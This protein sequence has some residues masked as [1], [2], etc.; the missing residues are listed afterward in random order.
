[1]KRILSLL[2]VLVMCVGVFAG[3]NNDKDVQTG[4]TLEQA[5]DYLYNIMKDKN[6]K[7]TP[8]DYDVVGKIIIDSTTFEVTWKTDNENIVVKESSKANCWTIDVP[9]VNETEVKYT[10]TATIKNAAGETIEVS[11][12][13]KLPVIDNA[14]VETEFKEGVA[15]K[16]F[17]KQVNLGYTVY[18]LNTTQNGENKYIETTMDPKEAATFYVEVV[19][20]GYK[21]YTE[22]DGVK[23]YLHAELKAV[24]GGKTSKYIGFSA[25]S[26][27]VF[28]YDKELS[29][30][31]V[32][33][34]G[35][36]YGVG[37]YNNFDTISISEITYFKA[38]NINVEDG[39]F[40]I[41]L[42]TKEYADTLA[43]S[44]KPEHVHEY[45]DGFCSC[46]EA[47]PNAA[48]TNQAPIIT[49][50]TLGLGAYADGSKTLGGV[51]FD[52]I[53]LGTYGDGIQWRNKAAEGGKTSTLWNA[54]ATPMGIEK[55]EITLADGKSG[56]TNTDAL[57]FAFGD[58]A[59]ALTYTTT[60]STEAGVAKYTITPD[61]GTYKFFKIQINITYTVY[62][63]RITIY[64]TGGAAHVHDFVDGECA[65]GESDPDYVP[66]HTC[67]D[68]NGDYVCDAT[69]C[70][71]VVAPAADSVL[72]LEQATAFGVALG[73]AYST[74]KYYVTG[75]ITEVYN[76]TYGNMYIKN[77]NNV[78]FT[79]YGLYTADGATRYD[80]M[81]TKPIAGDVVT[82]YGTIGSYNGTAQMKNGW[83]TD[84]QHEH[85]FEAGECACG[86]ADPDYVP[87]HTCVDA[88]GDY[89]CDATDCDKVVAPAA[90]SVLTLEQA[91]A[92]GVALGGAYSTDKYYV[93]GTITE[94][95]N[96]TYGNAYIK[97]TNNV[98]FTVY[99][100]Y[101]ADGATR[102][103][104]MTTKPVAGDVITVYGTIGSYSGTA[105]MKNGWVT[106]VQHTHAFEA[107][108]CACGAADPDYV[109][110]HEH[111]FVNGECA[112]G[113]TDPN[114]N[115]SE[116][117]DTQEVVL[118]ENLNFASAANK[119]SADTYMKDNYSNWTITGK[120]GQTYGGY[121]GF[122]RSGDV[123]SSIKSSAISVNSEFTITT[124]L[125][126]NGSSGVATSTL[127]FTL[128]DAN[129]NLVATGYADGAT[130]A[131][132]TPVDAKDTTYN[133]SFTLEDGK[134]W[135]DVSNLVISFSKATGN[136]G[137]KS[138]TFVQ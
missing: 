71:K 79:V 123:T 11:F 1:M 15:Y 82:A 34:N 22:I 94:V 4:A 95:Y 14:G 85:A 36:D 70:G 84:L 65:C 2:L 48:V 42:M 3:C 127:T 75:T 57:I 17:M 120:L 23:N 16:I 77:D 69:D 110:P 137:L 115:P 103:D 117:G 88:N 64:Y 97:D 80:A 72:T 121:L 113:E 20:G 35:G 32:T 6:D 7:A 102:Y 58:S 56:Y 91:N 25:E 27:C 50:E 41:G 61:A 10:L 112:C 118:P 131:A 108:Q 8:N 133:I 106:D 130:T 49:A 73:G 13:P 53:E 39:Q 19:D 52:F 46:G 62:I 68:A 107:G 89:V 44:E 90:D 60:M 81:A 109:A 87:T 125:K 136:I 66:T 45:V 134:S 18:A 98:Q 124:V 21:I 9:S 28:T 55:I 29:L 105:Q 26:N 67:A 47:D 135:S 24:D 114:Y 5:K 37:T 138:L 101:T 83:M 111:N 43:P 126:G 12:T 76:T 119:A 93:T 104:A 99:G 54:T 63:E 116:G 128:V 33:L 74:D 59:D 92:L 96:T 78:Q 86:A 122:G 38:D 129:G 31:K 132:I 100:M 30:F 40:P 51:Q